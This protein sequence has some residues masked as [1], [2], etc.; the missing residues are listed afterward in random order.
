MLVSILGLA[1]GCGS[2][3]PGLPDYSEWMQAGVDPRA[4]ADALTALLMRAGYDVRTRLEGESWVAL[5]ARRGEQRAIRVVTSR[6]AALVL[7]SHEADRVRVRHGLVELVPP[8]RGPTSH[9]LDGDGLDEVVVGAR[10]EGRVCLLPFRVDATGVIAPVPPDLGDL[11]GAELCVESFRDVDDNGRLEGIAV[12]RLVD[13]ARDEVP[14][15]EVPLE[16]DERHRFRVGPPPVRWIDEQRRARDAELES[17]LRDVDPERVYRV[18]V[19]L[20]ALARVTG[21]DR[22]AQ[23]GAFDRAISR[24]VLTE[25]LARDVRTAR[26]WIAEGWEVAR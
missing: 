6:G 17:A 7:D 18:A 14:L 1:S 22:E 23:L 4:E 5:D 10:H 21:G 15:V 3:R 11:A 25:P 2:P 13:L 24:V 16:L 12:L 20:A 26:S 9:D 19:E 8:P